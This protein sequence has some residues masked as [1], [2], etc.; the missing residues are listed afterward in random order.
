MFIELHRPEPITVNLN[1]LEYFCPHDTGGTLISVPDYSGWLK[2]KESYE[3]VQELI[4][5]A[6][7]GMEHE[8]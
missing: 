1:K 2:V 8:R 4:K 5:A 7:R 3:E 6:M